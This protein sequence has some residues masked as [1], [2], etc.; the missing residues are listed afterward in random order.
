MKITFGTSGWRA[1]IAEDFTFENVKLVSQA[2]ADY[3]HSINA[4]DKGIIITSDTR[5]LGEKLREFSARIL[6]ANGIKV[7]L[8]KRDTPT[9]VC[10]YEIIRRQTAGG[11]NFTASHNPPFYQG[12][13]YSP[14]TG[15]PAP[16]ETTKWIENRIQ[17]ITQTPTQLELKSIQELEQKKIVE[18][19][20][21]QKEYFKQLKKYI[22]FNVIKK[23]NLKIIYDCMH[24]TGRD[25]LDMALKQNGCKVEILNNNLDPYFGGF[26]PEP[27]KNNMP[28]LIKK[29]KTSKNSFGVAT[30]GDADR[31][32]FVDFDGSCIDA[33]FIIALLFDYIIKYKT[34]KGSVVRTLA[35]TH[36]IDSIA[37]K[38]NI[39]LHDVPVG[40]KFIGEV[41]QREDILI[42]GE[43]SG[44]LTV[45]RHVP[46]KDGIL[47]CLLVIEM[48]ARTKK[49]LKELLAEVYK[50]YGTFY[51]ARL[52]LHLDDQTKEK[53]FTFLKNDTPSQINNLPVSKIDD[54]DGTKIILNDGS[55][56]LVRFSGT[57]PIVRFYV[58][59]RTKKQL[60]DL[61]KYATDLL[62]L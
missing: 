40:F 57:E 41:M 26:P 50:K 53:L 44:G 1:I 20:D 30:D 7:F 29:I 17:Q 62:K 12:I 46:E 51:T 19:I 47:A 25:Y 16:P 4:Q 54:R 3:I 58:E 59:A 18:I 42:G 22:D 31:F 55:W 14:P 56:L 11:I 28:T 2:I 49:S 6:A 39:T 5:F 10:A 45:H 35:T 13:K 21:P 32:G 9:P 37:S 52:N 48:V 27:T 61:Q 8:T 33:N 24:G 43:E 23:S 15:A 60:N 38:N 34:W 36:L